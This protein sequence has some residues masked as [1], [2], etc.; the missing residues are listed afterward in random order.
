VW[1]VLIQSYKQ[2]TAELQGIFAVPRWWRAR[3]WEE[4]K[5]DNI[6]YV[7]YEK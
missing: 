7:N 6:Y 5:S 4:K 1:V 2:G 3:G